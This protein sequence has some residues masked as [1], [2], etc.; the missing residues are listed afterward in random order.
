MGNTWVTAMVHF[1]DEE[2]FPATLFGPAA[3]LVTHLGAIT[4]AATVAAAGEVVQT[5]LPCRRRPGRRPCPGRIRLRREDVPQRILWECPVC[6][7]HG[8]I[9]GWQGTPWDLTRR[10]SGGPVAEEGRATRAVWVNAA[11]YRLLRALPLLDPEAQRLVFGAREE[12]AGIRLE[13]N[14]AAFD[15]LLEGLA[16]ETNA[17][18]RGARRRDLDA[19]YGHLRRQAEQH[20][21]R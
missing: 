17:E 20:P 21:L 6:D 10:R 15:E 18:Q 14:A 4:S 5:P 19:L 16:S 1:L 2:G 9:T 12:S 11:Q 13:G 3:G 7:D 8:V